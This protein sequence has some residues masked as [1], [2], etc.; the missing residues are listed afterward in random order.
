[1]SNPDSVNVIIP[2]LAKAERADSL[3]HSLDILRHQVNVRA[4]PIIVI[5]GQ[6]YDPDLS[7]SLKADPDLK[8]LEIDTPSV[9]Q[10]RFVGRQHVNTEFFTFLDDDDEFTQDALSLRLLPLKNDPELDAVVTNGFVRKLDN[11]L[12]TSIFKSFPSGTT[13]PA[14]ALVNENW[15]ASCGG[16]FRTSTIGEQYFK[17]L[18][19]YFEWTSLA[20]ELA[21]HA[22]IHFLDHKTFIV[23]QTP[24]SLSQ[25][26][27]Y[28]LEEPE[29]LKSIIGCQSLPKKETDILKLRLSSTY[30][31]LA[32]HFLKD[33]KMQRS[34]YYHYKCTVASRHGWTYTPW[35]RHFVRRLFS[36][37]QP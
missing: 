33:G 37:R 8:V 19:D 29:L 12:L 15:L 13:S 5:N 4:Q 31:R 7:R 26:L 23:N 10:A 22:R 18:K 21:K 3:L 11:H 17:D 14:T 34:L 27:E 20:F 25:S 2:T 6:Q 24:A 35:L 16:L 32:N 1:M 9:S 36:G 30:N 28:K